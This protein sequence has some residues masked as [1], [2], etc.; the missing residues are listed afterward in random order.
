MD[1]SSPSNTSLRAVLVTWKL[2]GQNGLFREKKRRTCCLCCSLKGWEWC[3][4]D[5]CNCEALES[6]EAGWI[7]RSSPDLVCSTTLVRNLYFL[8]TKEEWLHRL[9]STVPRRDW[10]Q[11]DGRGQLVS[12][13]AL[14]LAFSV[15]SMVVGA[16]QICCHCLSCLASI[17]PFR[18]WQYLTTHIYID[19]GKNQ[20]EPMELKGPSFS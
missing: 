1:I 5:I 10:L 13:L 9:V 8:K 11:G 15:R 20:N 17:M 4:H 2:E 19:Q 14:H 18:C 16:L 7:A 3:F 6:F 12:L